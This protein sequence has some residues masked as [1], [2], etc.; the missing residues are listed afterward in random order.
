MVRTVRACRHGGLETVGSSRSGM[1]IAIG[2]AAITQPDHA[3]TPLEC[4][5]STE[6]GVSPDERRVLPLRR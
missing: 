5:Q 6:E 3:T 2:T 4:Q 1:F